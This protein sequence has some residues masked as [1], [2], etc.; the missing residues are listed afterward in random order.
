MNFQNS[1]LK[2]IVSMP[3]L[4]VIEYRVKEIAGN[5]GIIM[6]SRDSM[7]TIIG[8]PKGQKRVQK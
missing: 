5:H 3:V 8:G 7:G 2:V 1:H 4:K 6:T